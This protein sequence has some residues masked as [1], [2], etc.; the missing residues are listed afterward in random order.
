MRGA[1]RSTTTTE[2][3]TAVSCF[4]HNGRE[5][6]FI[7]WTQQVELAARSFPGFIESRLAPTDVMVL[8]WAV[9]VS[10]RSEAEMHHWLDSP[11]RAA[12]L[13]AGEAAGF[14]RIS[15][16]VVLTSGG[17]PPTGLGLFRHTVVADRADEFIAVQARLVELSSTFSGFEGATL[18][19]PASRSATGGELRSESTRPTGLPPSGAE[20]AQWLSV[21]RFRTDHQLQAWLNSAARK[22]ALPQLRS[23]LTED[24]SAITRSTP[25]AAI[26]RVQDGT[27]TVTPN[28]KTAM[29]VLLVLYPTVMTLSRFLGPQLDILG[30]QPWL[31]MW[32]SQIVSVALMTWLL[33]PAVTGWFRRW[34]DP[35]DGAGRRISL[36]GALVIAVAYALTLTLFAT[37]SWLQFWD[38]LD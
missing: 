7:P 8:D 24:F 23:Q 9:A 6:E 26:L 11:A 27:T 10:F 33:M 32:L 37:V 31:S 3:A 16:D 18:L 34:L 30:A 29:L 19:A 4:R 38:Y 22:Q 12:L 1:D 28:W 15:T 5:E 14:V 35:V 20:S 13:A 36:T 17:L 2:N 25:F 21:L